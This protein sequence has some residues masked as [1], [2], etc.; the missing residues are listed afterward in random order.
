MIDGFVT[1]HCGDT[2]VTLG[3]VQGDNRWLGA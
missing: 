1:G 3:W 2:E